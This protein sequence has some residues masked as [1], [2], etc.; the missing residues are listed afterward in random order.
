MN[1]A[2]FLKLAA[3]AT[4]TPQFKADQVRYID[5]TIGRLGDIAPVATMAARRYIE[6]AQRRTLAAANTELRK[7]AQDMEALRRQDLNLAASD[8]ELSEWAK[9]KAKTGSDLVSQAERSDNPDTI[10]TLLD[11]AT[12]LATRYGFK[13]PNPEKIG[14]LPTMRRVADVAWWRRQARTAAAHEVE[15][16]AVLLR[17]VNK[18]RAIYCSN[19]TVTRRQAQRIR[20]RKFLEGTEAT[21]EDGETYTL[22]EL[23]DVS[24]SNPRLMRME[25]MTRLAGFDAVAVLSGHARE[26]WTITAPAECHPWT[27]A[28]GRLRENPKWEKAGRPSTRQTMAQ[29]LALWA[30]FR[31]Y[32][33]RRGV[34]LYGMRIV[35]ANHDGTPH[36]HM[37]VYF[38]KEWPGTASRQASPRLRAIMR[39]YAL[40]DMATYTAQEKAAA[41]EHR[42]DFIDV[43]PGKSAA[44]YLAKYIAKA[45]PSSDAADLVQHDLYGNPT[46]ESATRVNAWASANRVRQFQQIGGPSV[47]VW[48]E[49]RRAT[50]NEAAQ[51]DLLDAPKIIQEAAAAADA[52]DWAAFVLIMGGPTIG[53]KGQLLRPGYWHEH[54]ND[55]G[56]IIGRALTKY[57]EIPNGRPY[58]VTW[59]GDDECTPG[60]LLTRAHTWTVKQTKTAA[61]TVAGTRDMAREV[62]AFLREHPPEWMPWARVPVAQ[63]R[64]AIGE[65]AQGFGFGL[66]FG[67]GFLI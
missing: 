49:L 66:G 43:L 27:T 11:E 59:A 30:A 39:R 37:A 9:A 42:A 29:F 52:A 12:D 58:G 40:G 62:N 18:H 53:R 34:R 13:L 7:M 22:A 10:A 61:P 21:N 45:L 65:S 33:A 19:E 24:V 28:G 16:V 41:K 51:L 5:Q 57:G 44:G 36:H 4:W 23:A 63:G 67:L 32:I 50:A 35:E 25:W 47:T 26:L 56:E 1:I 17:Q 2:P 8:D 54:D 14:I 6:T 60:H 31:S 38:A 64:A 20:N 3:A 55:T 15:R 46:E 48:R